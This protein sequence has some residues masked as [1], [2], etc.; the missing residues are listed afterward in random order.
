MY[1]KRSKD[2]E[3]LSNEQNN[4]M[5]D[6]LISA[7]GWPRSQYNEL[8]AY[9]TA[10]TCTILFI[11]H[12]DFRLF[13]SGIYAG[14]HPIEDELAL[15][16]LALIVISGF[17]LSIYHIFTVRPKSTIEKKF[18]GTFAIG[19]NAIAGIMA[20]L[21]EINSGTT[22][23]ILFPVWNILVGLIMLIQLRTGLFDIT[24][25]NVTGFQ[26]AAA[27]LTLFLVYLVTDKFFH[28]T[29]A[30]TFSVCMFYSSS[31]LFLVPWTINRIR[32]VWPKKK[33]RRT[34]SRD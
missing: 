18:M 16:A 7:L 8:T 26:A 23:L 21:E 31:I 32:T 20:A 4:Q 2:E 5:R 24:D 6:Y 19:A 14:N 1:K 30:M 15:L 11:V 10:L 12:P 3:H 29:W 33:R 34:S 25:E 9:L 17:S 22:L 27:S 28:L 13:L